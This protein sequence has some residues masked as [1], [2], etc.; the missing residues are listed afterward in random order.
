MAAPDRDAMV[1]SYRSLLDAWNRRD[2]H[3]FAALFGAAG[4]TLRRASGP[5]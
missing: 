2:A 3:G 1:A 5:G 4:G